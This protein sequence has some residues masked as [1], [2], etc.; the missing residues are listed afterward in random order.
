MDEIDVAFYLM[1]FGEPY[2][3][4]MPVTHWGRSLEALALAHDPHYRCA[5]EAEEEV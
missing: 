4:P 1:T 5:V 2:V 3:G